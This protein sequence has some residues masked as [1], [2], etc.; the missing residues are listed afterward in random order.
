MNARAIDISYASHAVRLSG[1]QWLVAGAI[2]LAALVLV[3]IAWERIEPF[4]PG[5]DYRIPYTLSN[6]YWHFS[7]YCRC[8]MSQHRTLVIGDSVVWG[9]YVAK[10]QTLSHYLGELAGGAGFANLGVDGTHTAALEG[11]VRYYGQA[12]SGAGV[13]LHCNPLWMGSKKHDLQTDKEFQFNHPRLVPQFTPGIPC[14][15]ETTSGRI[16]IVIERRV[17]FFGWATHLQHAYF[18]GKD[19]PAWTME[20]PYDNPA[21]AV[22]LEL[23]EPGDVLRHEAVSWAQR[24]MTRQNTAWVPLSTS[25]Q[26]QSFQRLLAVLQQRGN[27]VFVIVGPFNEHMLTPESLARYTVLKHGAAAWLRERSIPHC[28]PTPLPSELY[29]DASHP[30]GEGY[31]L[32]A[33]Q[34]CENE[35]FVRFIGQ[36]RNR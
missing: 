8:A 35:A 5:P 30:L 33:K 29:A 12:V 36:R 1:R 32:L 19:I 9:E 31:R 14:Y 3:P 2:I 23:P 16:G 6:D 21:A 4:D 13:V 11:L 17:P 22:T 10:D 18:G 26:W 25:F 27:N 20:H 15:T 28:V 7:R 24:R 34:L